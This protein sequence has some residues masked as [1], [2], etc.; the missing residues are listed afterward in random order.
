GA[1][2]AASMAPRRDGI[3]GDSLRV[4]SLARV[5]T[6]TADALL[7]PPAARDDGVEPLVAT[8]PLADVL[9]QRE[10]LLAREHAL[11]AFARALMQAL[12]HHRELDDALAEH[13]CRRVWDPAARPVSQL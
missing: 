9:A 10:S 6:D 4:S 8:R 3:A 7:A 12:R 5:L 1:V 13:A 11:M 2:S